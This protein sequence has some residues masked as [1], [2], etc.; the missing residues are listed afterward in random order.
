L[1]VA[2]NSGAS[3]L[4]LEDAYLSEEE[5]ERLLGGR[6]LSRGDR[7]MDP[8][9]QLMGELIR[10]QRA[11]DYIPTPT[12]TRQQFRRMVELFDEPPPASVVTS[13]LSCPGPAGPVPLRLFAPEGDG[14]RALPLLLY[15]HGGGWVQGDLDTHQGVCGKL[16]AWAGCKVLAVDYR[17]APEHSFPAGLDDCRAA[18]RWLV[19]NTDAVGAD[20]ERLALGGDS[21]GGNLAVALCLAMAA[22][23]GPMPAAQMLIYPSLELGWDLPSHREL[24]DA[25]VLPRPR[26]LWYTAQY[27]GERGQV[28]DPLASPLRATDL[29]G[30]PP[31]MIAT[32][33]FDPLLDDG[34][35]YAERLE[36][37]GVPVVY[38]EFP[39]Q[40][41][42]FVSLTR[43]IPQGDVCLHELADWLRSRLD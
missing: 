10:Q 34:R 38:R 37:A 1:A 27:M 36:A 43:V 39:G 32:A 20:P 15:L 21:A 31:A 11:P 28:A 40:I 30:Q 26:V 8:K 23:G 3:R 29:H 2:D 6:R 22:E 7:V 25:F 42:A 35:L 16:A 9:A 24:A 5:A 4:A 41:H 33:G 13:D 17:L 19:G 14:R 12:E 18:W